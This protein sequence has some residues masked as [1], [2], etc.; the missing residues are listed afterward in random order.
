M[1]QGGNTNATSGK[2]IPNRLSSSP[3][4]IDVGG[5]AW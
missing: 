3:D 1:G 5:E 4:V 2:Q